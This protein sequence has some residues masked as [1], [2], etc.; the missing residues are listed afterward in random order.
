M[1][2]FFEAFCAIEVADFPANQIFTKF[3]TKSFCGTRNF[4]LNSK[5]YEEYTN[6]K[7]MRVIKKY[8]SSSYRAAARVISKEFISW[9]LKFSF[10]FFN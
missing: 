4:L 10:N 3:R 5:T 1:K 8:N 2:Q 9:T 7:Q 6:A